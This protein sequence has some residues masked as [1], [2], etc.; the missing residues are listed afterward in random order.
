MHFKRLSSIVLVHLEGLEGLGPLQHGLQV[1]HGRDHG[2]P[3]HQL[4][5]LAQIL[6]ES[7]RDVVVQ[8][9]G[10]GEGERVVEDLRALLALSPEAREQI[11][12][13]LGPCLGADISAAVEGAIEAGTMFAGTPDQVV[14]QFQKHYNYVGGYGHLLIMGQAGFLEHDDTVHGIKM[15]AREV[16][17][18][19]KQLYPGTTISGLSEAACTQ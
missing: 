2:R 7:Q 8:Q 15:F 1:L 11:W 13:V 4:P 18:R 10:A 19:L 12:S 9:S 5:L 16:Y 17:P 3:H 6:H 14:K